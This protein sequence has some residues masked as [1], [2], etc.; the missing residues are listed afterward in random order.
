MKYCSSCV[1]PDTRPDLRFDENNICDACKSFDEKHDEIN[2]K[3]REEEF[4]ELIGSRTE[5]NKYDCLIPVS[6]GKDSHLTLYYAKK[7]F[8]LNPLSNKSSFL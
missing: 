4:R 7:V 3:E 8:N 1:M 5:K 2:W 6:G